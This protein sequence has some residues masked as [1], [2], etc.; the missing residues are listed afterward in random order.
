MDEFETRTLEYIRRYE[1]IKKGDTVIA[2]LSGGA[3][4][5][6][7]FRFLLS[8]RESLGISLRAAHVN[9]AL[10]AEHSD[11]DEDFV[12]GLCGKYGIPV[13]VVRL[14]P[15]DHA[16][17][18]WARIERYDFFDRLAKQY[19]AKIATAHTANDNAE[20]VLFRLARG[21]AVR[22]AAGIPPVRGFLCRPILWAQREDVLSYLGHCKQTYVTDQTNETDDYARNRIRHTALPSLAFAHEG[23]VRNIARFAS[24]MSEISDYL[25]EEADKLLEKAAVKEKIS[26]LNPSCR[27]YADVLLQAPKVIQKA[28][29]RKLI[30]DAAQQEKTSLVPKAQQLLHKRNGALPLAAKT[31]FSLRQGILSI[32]KETQ[33]TKEDAKKWEHPFENGTFKAPDGLFYS[34][35]LKN[36]EKSMNYEKDMRKPLKFYADYGKIQGY[37]FFR[38]R[39][40]KDRYRPLG[41][42][43]SKTLK[44][45][46]TE[47]KV[48]VKARDQLPVLAWESTILWAAGFGFADGLAPDDT[49]K[50]VVAIEPQQT[51]ELK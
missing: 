40:A 17:E 16:S 47:Q 24:E 22:G 41:R 2:A 39:R 28:A 15:P 13:D 25:D 31:Y 46:F 51:E 42:G 6:A 23:A 45:F 12:R 18:E 48:P 19:H 21:T 26:T 29:L 33:G 37:P 43:V 35:S 44:D 5:V 11:A 10:R 32:E 30:A 20:T 9:H 50:I 7:L 36:Y 1:M 34:V 27:Y 4:S 8:A 38:T 3:D 14:I 49:T